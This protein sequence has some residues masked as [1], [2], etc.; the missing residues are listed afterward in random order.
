MNHKEKNMNHNWMQ[1]NRHGAALLAASLLFLAGGAAC[2]Y[3]P[4]EEAASDRA[5]S[6]ESGFIVVASDSGVATTASRLKS[7]LEAKGMRVFAEIDHAAGA[8]DA[9]TELA[10]TRLI[11]FG[12][13]KVG[14]PL[15]QCN[16]TVAIDLPQKMLIWQDSE[17]SVRLA[18]N[19][20]RYL[21]RRH[22]LGA[23]AG[24]V[25]SEHC[26]YACGLAARTYAGQ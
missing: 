6:A 8:K 4:E 15:M 22:G 1:S 5:E 19:D 7:A 26:P 20:P 13:P 16:R 2:D 25:S 14:T 10:P 21:E 12:N 9:G 18:Y 11:V 24:S 23:C 3:T 17:G